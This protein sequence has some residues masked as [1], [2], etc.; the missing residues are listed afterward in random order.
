MASAAAAP[1]PEL[2]PEEEE[3]IAGASERRRREFAEARGC[4]RAA[5]EALG[6]PA[7][8]IPATADGAPVWPAGVIGSI[9]HKGGYRA[10]V[11]ARE[12][13]LEG[14]GIDAEPDQ[15][16]PGRVLETV[17]SRAE[18]DQVQA[19]LGQR[20]GLAWD[21]LLF[22]AKEATV[23]AAHPLGLDVAGVRAVAVSLD[24][25]AGR[26]TGVLAGSRDVSS[27]GAWVRRAGQL[28]TVAGMA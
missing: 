1:T 12:T 26:F 23:K 20:P 27:S 10:A 21:R 19:L 11:V 25:D 5:L 2:Y 4:A 9:T 6:V 22:S 15:P 28:V 8:P 14:L 3:L 13:D 24:P 16:L 17:A 18:L 7:G